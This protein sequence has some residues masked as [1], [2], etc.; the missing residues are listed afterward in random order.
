[1]TTCTPIVLHYHRSL[2]R[3]RL[4]SCCCAR[5][6]ITWMFKTVCD[7]F[8]RHWRCD[9]QCLADALIQDS[10]FYS[11]GTVRPHSPSTQLT[12]SDFT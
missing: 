3:S 4:F 1:M 2:T 9:N 11:I 10:L 8:A 7:C 5:V 6:D 12:Q